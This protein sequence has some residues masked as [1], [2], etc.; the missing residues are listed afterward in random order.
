MRDS[1]FIEKADLIGCP[2]IHAEGNTVE[3]LARTS[4]RQYTFVG[5]V[6]LRCFR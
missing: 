5:L 6:F 4:S 3:S 1:R 2:N